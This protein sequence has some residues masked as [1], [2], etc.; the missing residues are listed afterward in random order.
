MPICLSIYASLYLCSKEKF[1]F[2]K[3][4]NSIFICIVIMFHTLSS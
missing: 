4:R 2:D 1:S 3:K